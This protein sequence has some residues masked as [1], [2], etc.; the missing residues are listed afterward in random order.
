MIDLMALSAIERQSEVTY[1]R[2]ER[3]WVDRAAAEGRIIDAGRLL[4][5][6]PAT[7]TGVPGGGSNGHD[8]HANGHGHGHAGG[9]GTGHAHPK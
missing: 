6:L 3:G 8:G 7:V 4:P 9:A 2:R 5:V 1:V